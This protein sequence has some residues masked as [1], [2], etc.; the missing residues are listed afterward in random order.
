MMFV[1][2]LDY[3]AEAR[4]NPNMRFSA[5]YW[6]LLSLIVGIAFAAAILYSRLF[7]GVHSL[8]Q[9]YF[10]ALLGLWFA[11]SCHFILRD[12]LLKLVNDLIQGRKTDLKQMY[13]ASIL[14]LVAVYMVQI[15]NYEVIID[16]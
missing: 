8:N 10:G 12:S 7:L 13:L 9:V 4:T 15:V 16:F 5:W 1:V 2:C 3:N 6:R 14:S 11:L